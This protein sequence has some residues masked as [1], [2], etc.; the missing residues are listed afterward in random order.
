M[1]KFINEIIK[2]DDFDHLEY[3]KGSGKFGDLV[4]RLMEFLRCFSNN[5][6]KVFDISDFEKESNINISD[7]KD[8]LDSKNDKT[9]FDFN[10]EL[11]NDKI[12]FSN[13]GKMTDPFE[14]VRDAYSVLGVEDFYKVIGNDYE[15][16]HL[17][18]IKRSMEKITS[19]DLDFTNVLD[20]ACGL[21]EVTNILSEKGIKNIEGCDPYL[22]NEYQN[23]TGK[24]CLKM[25][26]EDIA[27]NGLVNKYSS[28][29]CSYAMHLCDKS[30]LPNLLWNLSMSCDN[31]VI[32]SPNNK[33]TV[34]KENGWNILNFF[35]EG[36]CKN[37]IYRK[38]T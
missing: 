36:K 2:F 9:L 4:L 7:I 19:Y 14:S 38:N 3:R 1:A 29:F 32:I 24:K 13:M 5:N 20:L 21:G 12:Y 17:D 22:Y 15:N 6:E 30:S 23:R 34:K 10:I 31:L 8:M 33:P 11:K 18:D 16:P 28:I 26:F 27:R 37:K 25:T 35:K